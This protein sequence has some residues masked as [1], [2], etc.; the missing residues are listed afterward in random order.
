[1]AY[2]GRRGG[3]IEYWVRAIRKAADMGRET[4]YILRDAWTRLYEA[5]MERLDDLLPFGGVYMLDL[6]GATA[7]ARAYRGAGG[8]VFYGIDSSRTRPIRVGVKYVA[9]V[10]GT[11][12][13]VRGDG[14]KAEVVYMD[15]DSKH[16]PEAGD[17][18]NYKKELEI[19]MFEFEAEALAKT[20][21]DIGE[22]STGIEPVV[23]MD[24]PLV[25]PPGLL[26]GAGDLADTARPLVGKRAR[27]IGLLYRLG[28]PVVGYVKRL[29]GSIFLE[30]YLG[31]DV[32]ESY[33]GHVGDRLLSFTLAR[34]AAEASREYGLCSNERPIVIVSKPVPLPQDKAPDVDVYNSEIEGILGEGARIY[35]SLYVPGYC[36]G[37]R[38][39]AA[40]IEFVARPGQEEE[41]AVAAASLLEAVTVQG[42]YLPLP[43][44][45]AHRACTIRR[46]E[47]SKLLR[48]V[49]SK[50][51]VEALG[52][53]VPSLLELFS[54]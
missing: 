22:P 21:E 28:V 14:G 25:D 1:M 39:S 8:R 19:M 43:V 24:G 10:S 42:P 33:Q 4:A 53:G 34:A 11:S 48:E 38:R 44:I 5:V 54:D 27:L 35:T 2:R 23:V 30:H 50:H 3:S 15:V 20:I 18:S 17:L 26:S 47:G 49:A 41:T 7:A 13:K 52:E 12:V 9:F 40:R 29:R 16:V 37:N 46:R 36:G 51:V 45:L 6:A 31:R 32:M